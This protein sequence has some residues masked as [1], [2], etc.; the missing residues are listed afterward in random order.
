MEADELGKGQQNVAIF[1][2][3]DNATQSLLKPILE[4]VSKYGTPTI[5]RVY[6][7]WTTQAMQSWKR[8]I[9]DNAFQPVQ[10]YNVAK[11]KNSTDAALIID[12]MDV[13]Y[14]GDVGAFCIVS[15]DSDYTRLATRLREAGKLVV[16]V[17][18]RQTPQ[19]LVNACQIF[20]Y[21]EN[22][23]GDGDS[24]KGGKTT[25]RQ[26]RS[27]P[28]GGNGVPMKLLERAYEICEDETGWAELGHMG[29]KL[30]DLD[31]G[32]DPRTYGH[33]KLLDLLKASNRFDVKAEKRDGPSPIHIRLKD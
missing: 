9:L 5:R 29:N 10:Q 30:I 4:E 1:V 11:G 16:G 22:L 6:A 28:A 15:S 31:P 13:L 24:G 19:S 20:I 21:T 8:V 27:A 2:D 3:G 23:S 26:R 12:A 18:E 33:K 32:F 17:G 25:G 14:R 7:D